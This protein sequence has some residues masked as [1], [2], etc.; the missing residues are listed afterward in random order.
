VSSLLSSHP[1]EKRIQNR[2]LRRSE[3]E[4]PWAKPI[5]SPFP[6]STFANQLPDRLSARVQHRRNWSRHCRCLRTFRCHNHWRPKVSPLLVWVRTGF[7]V[8]QLEQTNPRDRNLPCVMNTK[9]HRDR[10]S[11]FPTGDFSTEIEKLK[12]RRSAVVVFCFS[13]FAFP[14]CELSADRLVEQPTH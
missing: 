8:I 1:Y 10:G 6:N 12:S 2:Q 3:K 7:R 9:P 4:Y 13:T 14:L 11:Y 5:G